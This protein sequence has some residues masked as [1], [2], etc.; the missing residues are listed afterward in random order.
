MANPMKSHFK[1]YEKMAN[2]SLSSQHKLIYLLY[3]FTGL[4]TAFVV[5]DFWAKEEMFPEWR[6][7]GIIIGAALGFLV[8]MILVIR[9]KNIS[10][11]LNELE[12]SEGY[13]DA[14][15]DEAYKML[16]KKQSNV[17]KMTY[18][19]IIGHI[20]NFRGEFSKTAEL[21]SQM[22]ESIFSVSPTNAHMYYSAL[23]MAYLMLGERERAF[24]V[25]NRGMYYMRTYMNSPVSGVCVSL[26]LAVYE[27]YAG[28]YGVSLQLLDNAL[29]AGSADV[30]PEHRIPNENMTSIICYWKALVFANMGNK[31]A[32]WE[33]IN[34]CKNFYKTPYYETLSDKLLEDMAEDEK[35]KNEVTDETIS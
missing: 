14:T 29:R 16:G 18:A 32:A 31:A 22:D 6:I 12:L 30:R 28:H 3:T 10:G 20:H 8:G 5:T 23:L 19:E 35:R 1:L 17:W 24:D 25:Y 26:S 2:R 27:F 11:R 21:L 9:S 4:L 34:Y 15:L 7:I 33:M 13:T